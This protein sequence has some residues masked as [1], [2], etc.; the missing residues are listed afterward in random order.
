M[1]PFGNKG[2]PD[3]WSS[4]GASLT[5]VGQLRTT[6]PPPKKVWIHMIAAT[7]EIVQAFVTP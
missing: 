3:D 5:A 7:K 4:R 2:L 6:P 1:I